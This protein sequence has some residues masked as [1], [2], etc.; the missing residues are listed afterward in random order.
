[1][2]GSGPMHRRWLWTA[3]ICLT[4]GGCGSLFGRSTPISYFD[5]T[6]TATAA[7]A[8]PSLGNQIIAVQTV[9][10]PDYLNQNGIVTRSDTNAIHVSQDSHWAGALSDNITN[11]IVADLSRLFASGKVVAFPVSA[12]LPV[13]RVVQMNINQFEQIPSGEVVLDAQWAIFADGGRSFL[14]A[15]A[16]AYTTAVSGDGYAGVA[17]AMSRLL[18]SLS[19]DVAGA[20]AATSGVP[21]KTVA[22]PRS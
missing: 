15:D 4:L 1:M 6:P 10:L 22:P 2:T 7:A 21:S 13:D 18:G 11:V 17:A 5:L 8:V 19:H 16:G 14:V 12:A 20:L 3:L 9:R